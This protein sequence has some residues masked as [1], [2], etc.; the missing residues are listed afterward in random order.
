MITFE[1]AQITGVE[2]KIGNGAVISQ[3]KV[4]A[5]LTAKIANELGAHW[6]LMDK[7]QTVKDGFK[8]VELDAELSNIRIRFEVPKLGHVLELTSERAEQ[9]KCLRKGDGK[10]KPKRLMVQ[11]RIQHSGSPFELLEH[12]IR[13]GGT[14]GVLTIEELQR[15]MFGKT[16]S[17][18]PQTEKNKTRGRPSKAVREANVEAAIV[19]HNARARGVGPIPTDDSV[20]EWRTTEEIAAGVPHHI[21][22]E[23]AV[24]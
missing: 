9:F 19:A 24:Q 20:I 12:M 4:S 6:I 15:K 21:L 8:S 3:I 10:K 23:D 22:P 1:K 17:D 14:E 11:F 7:E 2:H 5:S 16:D 13:V 18:T